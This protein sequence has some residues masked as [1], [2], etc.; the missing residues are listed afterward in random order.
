MI[1]RIPA[2][3]LVYGCTTSP[4]PGTRT[5][6]PSIAISAGHIVHPGPVQC[7]QLTDP[8]TE[9]R[10]NLHQ[11]AQVVPFRGGRYR[12]MGAKAVPALL[13]QHQLSSLALVRDGLN[14]RTGFDSSA[15]C[16]TASPSTPGRMTLAYFAVPGPERSRSSPNHRVDPGYAKIAEVERTNGGITCLVH[17]SR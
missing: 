14:S 11:V 13:G 15:S 2:S 8:A 4:S 17:T 5:T 1:V 7:E 3:D 16:R 12:Q 6:V 10:Q 9:S